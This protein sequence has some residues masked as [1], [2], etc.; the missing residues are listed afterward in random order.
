MASLSITVGTEH[1]GRF[2]I[3]DN[4]A[5]LRDM[6]KW[7]PVSHMQQEKTP[8]RTVQQLEVFRS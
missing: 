7:T 8:S 1:A 4:K 3:C 5:L 2:K 6:I